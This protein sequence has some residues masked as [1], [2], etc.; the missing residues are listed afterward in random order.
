MASTSPVLLHVFSLWLNGHVCPNSP[1]LGTAFVVKV[2]ASLV[3]PP[4][5]SASSVLQW[6]G[7]NLYSSLP[8][9]STRI[10]LQLSE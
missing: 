4:R 5:N 1:V 3:M 9:S 2:R 6:Y 10:R 7:P 8:T